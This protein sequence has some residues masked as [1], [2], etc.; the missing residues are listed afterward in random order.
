MINKLITNQ[1][2]LIAISLSV[3]ICSCSSPLDFNFKQNSFDQDM[4]NF[5]STNALSRK[6]SVMISEWIDHY[7]MEK[8]S[9]EKYSYSKILLEAKKLKEKKKKNQK[10]FRTL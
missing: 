2:F 8:D 6:D 1:R 3:I 10:D 9:L 7:E 4:K 5:I